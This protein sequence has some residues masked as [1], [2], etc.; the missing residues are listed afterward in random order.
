MDRQCFGCSRSIRPADG[1]ALLW[2]VEPAP[3]AR[4]PFHLAC[5]LT[6]RDECAAQPEP[7]ADHLRERVAA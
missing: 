7:A 5:W 4:E 6:W 3:R 2:D 1:P